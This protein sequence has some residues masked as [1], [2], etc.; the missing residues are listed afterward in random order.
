MKVGILGSD[1]KEW[2]IERL[3]RE[4]KGRGVEAYLIPVTKL[5]SRIGSEPK[6]SV[7]GYPVEGYD[8][9]IVRRM[10][11]GTAERVF[12]RMDTLHMLEEYGVHVVNPAL[13]I[14]KSVNKCYTSALLEK[15]GLR[16]PKTV[17]TES[18]TES[19]RAFDELEG[20]VVVKP[21]FGSLG[22]GITRLTDRDIAYRVFRALEST[23]S[24]FYLQEY[25]PHG[26][27][28]IRVFVIGGEVVAS[29]TRVGA[30]WK[31]NISLGGAPEPYEPTDEETE[32]SLKAAETMELD[33][34]GVDLLRSE[35]DG[36]LYTL[37]VNSTPGWEGLQK[38]TGFD[39]AERLVDHVIKQLN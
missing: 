11:G 28:D 36:A 34:T 22:A 14:E 16:S 30:G 25:I 32:A 37:E 1:R 3:L 7:K 8:A 6:V 29:M 33:Y 23:Q 38:V 31:T 39:I 27:R 19:M 24:V 9:L 4:L 15:A 18:F 26:N 20:D 13:S 21:L 5:V 2:H 17:I 35:T 10:P 12:Y